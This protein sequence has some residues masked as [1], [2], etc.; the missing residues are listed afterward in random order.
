MHLLLHPMV[1]GA[2]L[3]LGATVLSAMREAHAA[4]AQPAATAATEPAVTLYMTPSC[5]YCA[6]ARQLLDSRGIQ[7][8]E[9][10]I[11]DPV[12]AA[13]W[14]ALGGQGVPLLIVGQTRVQGFDQARIEAALATLEPAALQTPSAPDR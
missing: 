9:R 5:G 14:R 12:V 7:Y 6:R 2:V 8:T 3:A 13:E 11:E 1:L 4:A 10:D